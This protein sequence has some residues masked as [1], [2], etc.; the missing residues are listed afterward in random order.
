MRRGHLVQAALLSAVAGGI[1]AAVAVA[2]R[3]LP[4]E[5]STQAH[6]IFHLY[7]ILTI[8]S[9]VIF[10]IVLG[11][12]VFAVL[13][14]R[15]RRGDEEDGPPVHGNTALEV[16][17]TAIPTVLVVFIAVISAV[18]LT[19]NGRAGRD[20]LQVTAVGEQFAWTFSYPGRSPASYGSLRLPLGRTVEF[21]L[22]SRDVLH[23]F[24]VPNFAQKQD[25]VP[26]QIEHLVVTPTRLGTY[27]V[28][29]TQLCG[30]G[31]GIMRSQVT[32][33]PAAEFDKWIATQKSAAAAGAG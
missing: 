28:I 17:W 23:G 6:R 8:I 18:V 9:I 3:W 19:Q 10:A 27:P 24:W 4:T 32:V 31:H 22:E 7:W 5:A 12:L 21:T 33:M 2:F 25:T 29:C 16:I 26:G 13:K 14:F 20:P 11:P 15:A 1:A 30:L